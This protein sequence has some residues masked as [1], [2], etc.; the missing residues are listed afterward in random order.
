LNPF[1]D[2]SDQRSYFRVDKS[3][4]GRVSKSVC[5]LG[6]LIDM[7]HIQEASVR[8]DKLY[9][10]L[11][12]SSD[13]VG[14]AG[15]FPNYQEPWE[16]ILQRVAK[17]VVSDKMMVE[18]RPHKDAMI[19]REKAALSAE[20]PQSTAI[21]VGTIDRTLKLSGGGIYWSNRNI[22]EKS[23]V[24]GLFRIRQRISKEGI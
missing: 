6:E 22:Q 8:H 7:Y 5:A 4:L 9:A 10:L 19:L 14:K 24:A 20:Y 23:I 12:M 15:L 21:L 16:N 3:R 11:G 17:F 13:D 1:Y 2:L 18:S